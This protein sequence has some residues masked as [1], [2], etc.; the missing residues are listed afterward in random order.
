MHTIA[1]HNKSCGNGDTYGDETS[2]A[3]SATSLNKLTKY[4][5]FK[6]Q[7]VTNV[8]TDTERWMKDIK[9]IL[10][11]TYNPWVIYFW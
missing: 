2:T 6:Q 10:P 4:M 1:E 8:C 11:E 3:R 5:L 9:C 7:Q